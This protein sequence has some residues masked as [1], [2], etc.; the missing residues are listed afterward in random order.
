M[1]PFLYRKTDGEPGAGESA[2]LETDSFQLLALPFLQATPVFDAFVVRETDPLTEDGSGEIERVLVEICSGGKGVWGKL[3]QGTFGCFLSG[4]DLSSPGRLK[5]AFSAP[6]R[7]GVLIGIAS[8]P[9]LNYAKNEILKNARK[10]LD[11]AAFF[12]PGSMVSF[13]A[14]SLN[15]SGDAF[16]QRGDVAT[17]IREF[18]AALMLD[19]ANAN[20][21]NSLGV[22]YGAIGLYPEALEAFETA[23]WLEPSEVMAVFNIGLVHL[24]LGDRETALTYMLDAERMEG[25]LFEPAF[26]IGKLYIEMGRPE[27]AK[28]LLEKAAR[29]RPDS[30]PAFRSL[31]ECYAA[32]DLT[33][34]AAAAF[35]TAVKLNPNDAVSL[36]GLGYVF[37]R[38]GENPEI[39]SLFCRRS[40]E[41][42]PENGLFRYRLARLYLK[43]EQLEAALQEFRKAAA[44]GFE[45]GEFI[46]KLEERLLARAS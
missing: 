8:Y 17:A 3:E 20:V 14:I 25:E 4:R 42:S 15:V 44:L 5:E 21:H 10:A 18:R 31:G 26:Q 1:R 6:G 12:G 30:A 9:T 27:D 29:L 34:E 28:P 35:K 38:L 7:T 41:I 19:P 45:A 46:E 43:Q 36:S 37:D 11:H 2:P 22:C 16:Y 13:D 40:I 23:A 32:L 24:L 39:A 33:P